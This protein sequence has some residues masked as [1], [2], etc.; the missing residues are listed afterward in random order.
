MMQ[1]NT[2]G[3]VAAATLLP[4]V[5]DTVEK[6]GA[7]LRAEFHRPGGPRG[8][9]SKAAIDIEIEA[10]LRTQL[11]AIHPADWRGEE[12][13]QAICGNPD[14]WVVD[15]HDGTR[16]FLR[17]LRGPSISV[18]L[19]RAGKPILGVVFA[20]T[21]PDDA[22]D[23]MTWAEGTELR[24]NGVVVLQ[25]RGQTRYGPDT[26]IAL[27]E[28]ATDYALVNHKR[29]APARVM[30]MP[31]IAY[32]LALAAVGEADLA[33]SLTHGLDAYDIAGG[34][35][36]LIGA[37]KMLADMNGSPISYHDRMSYVGCVGGTE[38]LIRAVLPRIG[39]DRGKVARHPA[40]PARRVLSSLMLSRAQGA[41]LGQLAG[42]ALG[43]LVE[44]KSAREISR[45]YPHGVRELVDGGA[46]AT[47]AGQPT[48]D[49]EMA[50]ALARS[51]VAEQGFNPD[52]AGRAYVAWGQTHSFDIGGTTS[53]GLAALAGRGQPSTVSQSNGALMRV[54]P[55]GIANAGQPGRAAEQARIDAALTHPHPICV[56]ASGC[57]AAAIAAGISGAGP[58]E[59]WAVAHAHAGEDVAGATV[60]N[61]L[62]VAQ[63]GAPEEYQ[64]QMGWVLIALQNAFHH[65]WKGNTL[66]DALIETVGCGGDTDTNAAIAGALLGAAQGREAI[67]LRWRRA[68]ATCCALPVPEVKR[69]RPT[70]YWPD[71]A[72]DLAEALLVCHA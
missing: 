23:M 20:P 51:I 7:L 55:L 12:T 17:G 41:L 53:Q 28:D 72:M 6:A 65:L 14:L 47:I 38:A 2:A 3:Q 68:L 45:L 4:R 30:A 71:D 34:H 64:R 40:R 52:A 36:L 18:A 37:G 46:W 8:Q 50:L 29:Y 49:S 33:V 19:L 70:V 10:F 32:R 59:M 21:A 60:R 39:S 5:I 69:P 48:D 63:L 11:Q 67:P 58:R 54:S 61:L 15:P 1:R 13:P 62:Q 35:A 25:G 26:V 16:G 57:Y 27:N 42:D 22:D 56:A 24:R 9:G 31:S 44:F 66:E 43:S